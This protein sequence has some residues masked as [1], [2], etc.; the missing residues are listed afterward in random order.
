MFRKRGNWKITIPVMILVLGIVFAM[1]FFGIGSFRFTLRLGY[2]GS[3][4]SHLVE[5]SYAKVSGKMTHTLSPSKDA[6]A[7]HCE[8]TTKEGNLNVK[9]TEKSTG[10]V[11]YEEVI[12]G[13]TTFDVPADGKVTINMSPE[14]HKGSFKFTY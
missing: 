1:K 6:T 11:L 9:L 5:G 2:A 7:V 12:S 10:K 3:Q 13:N 8:I 14:Y 4:T